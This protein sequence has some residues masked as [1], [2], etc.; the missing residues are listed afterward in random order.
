MST[1]THHS[2]PAPLETAQAHRLALAAREHAQV[3]AE[4]HLRYGYTY[5]RETKQIIPTAAQGERFKRALQHGM[6]QLAFANRV[7]EMT[8]EE[9]LTEMNAADLHVLDTAN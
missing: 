8:Y 1:V 6:R 4:A 7:L 5:D 2:S 3:K 9:L